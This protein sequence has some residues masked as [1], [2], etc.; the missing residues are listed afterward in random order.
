MADVTRQSALES[1]VLLKNDD[2]LP[3]D[4]ERL[5]RLALIGPHGDNARRFFGGYTHLSMMEST[6]AVANSIAGVAGI[7]NPSGKEIETVPGTNIQSDLTE[8]FDPILRR[9]KPGCPSLLDA[10]RA[11]LPDT[12]IVYA[13]GYPIAGD[14]R[15]GFDEALALIAGA[16]AAVLTLGG[17]YGTCSIASMGEGVDGTDINLPPCQEAFLRKAAA[18]C[19]PLVGVHFDG[20]PISSDGTD[21]CLDAILEAWAPSEAGGEAVTSVLTGRY[22]PGGRLPVSVA[23]NAG[24]LPVYYNHPWGSCEHQGE[25]IGFAS[26]VDLPHTPRYP[27]G[28]GLSYTT[29]QYGRLQ[30]SAEEL[31]PE[32]TLRVS[33]DVHNT[34]RMAGDEVVQIYLS[35]RYASRTRPVRELAGFKRLRLEPGEGKTVVFTVDFSQMAFLDKDMRWK[36]ERG[37]FDIQIGSSSVDIRV[38][39]TVRVTGDAWIDGNK[40]AMWAEVEVEA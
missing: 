13:P 5:C 21:R 9:Q 1:L 16:D 6:F 26:Y 3:L 23:Y 40:R 17:K 29:F 14:D 39:G 7:E 35:D 8:E 11:A 10:L 32:E 18:L 33:V 31:G 4:G 37:D 36:I 19:K 30:L 28:Y 20:R 25:S 24:Q 27:F 2:V 22:N 15:S 34:G 12:E 38:A